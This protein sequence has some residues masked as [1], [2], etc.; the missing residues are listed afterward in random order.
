MAAGSRE[1]FGGLRVEEG[2]GDNEDEG[3]EREREMGSR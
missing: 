2:C 1:S 3:K